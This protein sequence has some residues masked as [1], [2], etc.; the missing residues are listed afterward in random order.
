[1][2]IKLLLLNSSAFIDFLLDTISTKK[3]R[4]DKLKRANVSYFSDS[5]ISKIK[6][7]EFDDE[8]IDKIK[9]HVNYCQSRPKEYRSR[10]EV[11][12]LPNLKS[13]AKMM[14]H[15]IMRSGISITDKIINENIAETFEMVE[16]LTT[17][18]YW[19]SRLIIPRYIID[20]IGRDEIKE[21]VKKVVIESHHNVVVKFI[22][23]EFHF[24]YEE[25][26]NNFKLPFSPCKPFIK[27]VEVHSLLVKIIDNI[28]TYCN[29]KESTTC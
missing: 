6:N 14:L 18:C 8:L 10:I 26:I 16:I 13:D 1:M 12:I 22:R 17:Q 9:E 20:Y 27:R 28:N 21:I 24:S 11:N 3:P 23:N 2:D 29:V 7:K 4:N 5:M 25:D 15:L 19:N